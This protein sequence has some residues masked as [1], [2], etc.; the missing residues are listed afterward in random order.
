VRSVAVLA[1]AASVVAY[2]LSV[3][4]SA[5]A[6]A[7][8]PADPTASATSAPAET[9]GP[10]ATPAP[11]PLDLRPLLTAEVTVVNLGEGLL[12]V[13]AVALDPESDDEYELGT[14]ELEALQVTTQA[15]PPALFRL[16]FTYSDPP[17]VVAGTCTILIAEGEAIEFA[18]VETGAV[19]AAQLEPDAGGESVVTSARCHA[20]GGG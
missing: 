15:V 6:T 9:P 13:R 17:P 18:V 1:L 10:N 3:G 14:F 4:A 7:A 5:A 11:T 8:S 12:A 20:G 16:E 2:P 19:I